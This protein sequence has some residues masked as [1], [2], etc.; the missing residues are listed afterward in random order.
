LESTVVE[1]RTLARVSK[2]FELRQPQSAGR[3]FGNGPNAWAREEKI[4][5]VKVAKG[6]AFL[7]KVSK[8]N[9]RLS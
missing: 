7:P 4:S 8:A 5:G 2:L 3:A 9:E 1:S 6:T